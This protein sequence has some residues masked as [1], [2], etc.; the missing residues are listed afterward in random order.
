ML[1]KTEGSLFLIAAMVFVCNVLG[2]QT[3]LGQSTQETPPYLIGPN[4]ILSIFVWKEPELTREVTVMPDGR[5]TFPLAGEISA[6]GQTVS[7]LKKSV[8]QRLEKYITAPEVTVIIRESRSQTIYTLGKI[9]RPGPYPL[10]PNMTVLQ[11]LSS[12]GGFAEWADPKNILIVRREAGKEVQIPFNYKE[13][14]S[15]QNLGQN[16]LLKPGD[17]IVVP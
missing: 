17:T 9:L 11:A 15:G 12:A 5:I 1:R 13:L 16:I 4:D 2:P 8:T 6:Q 14:T 3:C 10:A 7:Q